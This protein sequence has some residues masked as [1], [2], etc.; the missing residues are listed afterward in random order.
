V[1]RAESGDL[2]F[3]SPTAIP[4]AVRLNEVVL[5][6]GDVVSVKL[7]GFRLPT[8]ALGA[9]NPVEAT[10]LINERRPV[11]EGFEHVTH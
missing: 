4:F 10:A 6:P 5:G 9:E 2:S 8:S 1:C 11:L 3:T 7:T